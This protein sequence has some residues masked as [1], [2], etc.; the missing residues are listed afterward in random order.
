MENQAEVQQLTVGQLI[1][2]LQLLPENAEV[3]AGV[4]GAGI[5][6]TILDLSKYTTADGKELVV[7]G[8]HPGATSKAMEMY[9]ENIMKHAGG[10]VAN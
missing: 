7:L 4:L 5:T 8:L 6:I 1:K 2:D 10:D 3:F 9:V